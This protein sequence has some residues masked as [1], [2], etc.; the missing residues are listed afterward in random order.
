MLDDIFCVVADGIKCEDKK[1]L[2]FS[3]EFWLLCWVGEFT[4]I[5]S[6]KLNFMGKAVWKINVG[7]GKSNHKI[8]FNFP[9][10]VVNLS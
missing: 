8:Q 3:V 5:F 7:F 1:A 10:T 4:G 9:A 6:G 2:K